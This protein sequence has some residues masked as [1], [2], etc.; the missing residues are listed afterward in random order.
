M[1]D[2]GVYLLDESIR[3]AIIHDGTKSKGGKKGHGN[4]MAA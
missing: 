3:G 2:E 4:L 1:I